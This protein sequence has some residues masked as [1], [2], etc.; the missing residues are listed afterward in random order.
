[1]ILRVKYD[2]LKEKGDFIGTKKEEI[3]EILDNMEKIMNRMPE[4]WKGIDSDVFV[5]KALNFIKLQK[6]NTNKVENLSEL[7]RIFSS[8]YK[9]KDHEWKEEIKKGAELYENRY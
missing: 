5:A 6:T 8:N 3:L 4:A 7:L 1:M 2:E 9:N